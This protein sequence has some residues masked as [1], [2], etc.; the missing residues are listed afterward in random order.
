MSSTHWGLFHMY[1]DEL[2]RD[3]TRQTEQLLLCILL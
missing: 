2:L 3:L 1:E